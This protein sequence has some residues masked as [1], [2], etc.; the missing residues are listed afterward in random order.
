MLIKPL[1]K[2]HIWT[3]FKVT[4]FLTKYQYKRAEQSNPADDKMAVLAKAIKNKTRLENHLSQTE[5]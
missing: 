4:E 2:K 3:D 1:L 5:R